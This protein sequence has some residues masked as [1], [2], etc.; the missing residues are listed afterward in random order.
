MEGELRKLRLFANATDES[1]E[2]LQQTMKIMF[3]PRG[4]HVFCHRNVADMVYVVY[5]G[6]F[7]IYKISPSNDKRII[8]LQLPGDLLNDNLKPNQPNL[9]YCESFEDSQALVCPLNKFLGIMRHDFELTQAV[10]GQFS[11]K[12]RKNYRQLKNTLTN[13]P[14]EKKLAARI[15]SLKRDF[16]VKTPQGVLID[17]PITI[18]YLSEML[19]ARRE[20]TSR[21]FKRLLEEGL[22]VY[23]DKKI[24]IP[25]PNDIL[26]FYNREKD[27]L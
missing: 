19:G 25:N 7:S 15:Y 20:T 3:Y 17:I 10:V 24:L 23:S 9:I 21:A 22:I 11:S 26:L 2:A 1:L 13:V 16:G 18:T 27:L 6:R 5:S 4:S 8:F 14:I 12:L